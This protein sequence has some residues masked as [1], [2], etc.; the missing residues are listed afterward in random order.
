MSLKVLASALSHCL[1]PDP[2]T[3]PPSY[4][5]VPLHPCLLSG[6]CC[7]PFTRK[8]LSLL[9]LAPKATRLVPPGRSSKDPV[10]ALGHKALP[11]PWVLTLP[12]VEHSSSITGCFHGDFWVIL[13]CTSSIGH[14]DTQQ[15]NTV[16]V[17]PHQNSKGRDS[18]HGCVA[19]GQQS[20]LLEASPL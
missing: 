20:P 4:A 16:L 10:L 19:L 1:S 7:H 15:V 5:L 12:P 9:L 18:G 6:P 14:P 3:S 11:T 13:A 2:D 8:G 17:R